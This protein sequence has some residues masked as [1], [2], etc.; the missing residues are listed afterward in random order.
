MLLGECLREAGQLLHKRLDRLAREERDCGHRAEH[1]EGAQR[2]FL[3]S[4]LRRR[5]A[6]PS[7]ASPST[8]PTTGM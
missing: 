1:Y 7:S 4:S 2:D 3:S 6:T 8:A 5:Y